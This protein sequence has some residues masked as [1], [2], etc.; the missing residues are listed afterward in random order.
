M[1]GNKKI[2]I[3]I[4]YDGVILLEKVFMWVILVFQFFD[5]R[6]KSV[7]VPSNDKLDRD[8]IDNIKK[9]STVISTWKKDLVVYEECGDSDSVENYQAEGLCKVCDD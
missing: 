2:K 6:L 5:N 1:K 7:P 9:L 8:D 3:V 4:D